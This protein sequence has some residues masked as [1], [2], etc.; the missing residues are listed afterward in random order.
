[1]DPIM[2]LLASQLLL[3]C[4]ILLASKQTTQHFSMQS[5]FDK[6]KLAILSTISL[7]EN[8]EFRD[9]ETDY[10][11]TKNHITQVD[12]I[13]VSAAAGIAIADSNCCSVT[14]SDSVEKVNNNIAKNI[15][16]Q[17]TDLCPIA[18]NDSGS[19]YYW[20]AYSILHI[21]KTASSLLDNKL[22]K[23]IWS[24]LTLKGFNVFTRHRNECHEPEKNNGKAQCSNHIES[25][26]LVRIIAIRKAQKIARTKVSRLNKLLM[27]ERRVRPMQTIPEIVEG[28]C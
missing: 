12:S 5:I 28:D 19:E 17:K 6:L 13:T 26:F 7:S 4:A 2:I 18:S 24:I 10:K 9:N 15:C 25:D 22:I 21:A 23:Y 27:I 14:M 11:V 8:E 1:M 20:D 3:I 16:E